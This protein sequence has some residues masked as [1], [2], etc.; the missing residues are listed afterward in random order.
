MVTKTGSCVCMDPHTN[1]LMMIIYV[2]GTQAD[3]SG[4]RK[5]NP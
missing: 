4:D 1:R 5:Y 3:L 2:T